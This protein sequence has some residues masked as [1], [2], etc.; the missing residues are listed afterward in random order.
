VLRDGET[1]QAFA[2]YE[3]DC[4]PIRMAYDLKRAKCDASNRKCLMVIK[5]SIKEA[6]R[7][8]I[9]DCKTAKE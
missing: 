9:L 4:A 7:E 6:I 2:T 1:V 3:R 8:G 5:S